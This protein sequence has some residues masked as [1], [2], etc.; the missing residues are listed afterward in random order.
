MPCSTPVAIRRAVLRAAKNG[1]PVAVLAGRFHL[2]ERTL[3]HLIQRFADQDDVTPA[4]QR[5]G[6]SAAAP[7]PILEETL[8]LRRAHPSWGGGLI[9]V[10]LQDEHPHKQIPCTR[11]LQRWLRR[12]GEAVAPPGRRPTSANS[13]AR[14]PHECWQVDAA[15]QK[16]LKSGPL[17]SWLRVV[18]ECSGAVLKTVVFPPR[19]LESGTR[20]RNPTHP[21][22]FVRPLGYAATSARGQRHAMGFVE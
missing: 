19:E 13:R 8:Q 6:R 20:P 7:S 14:Q 21:A 4:Y 12:S 15:E 18:D 3:R 11:T 9:R 2:P 17:I 1:A 10:M 5:C 16:R 22:G